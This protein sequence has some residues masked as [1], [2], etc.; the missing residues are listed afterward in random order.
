MTGHSIGIA[1]DSRSDG[2]DDQTDLPCPIL[3]LIVL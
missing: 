1:V 2:D 3:H